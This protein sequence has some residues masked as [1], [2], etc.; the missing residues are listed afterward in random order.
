[1]KKSAF[2]LVMRRG[3]YLILIVFILTSCSKKQDSKACY[4]CTHN[5]SI[6][7]NIP[8]I[9]NAHAMS[10]TDVHCDFTNAQK[11]FYINTNNYADTIFLRND[12][13]I[14]EFWTTTCES[15]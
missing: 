8:K 1:M 9:V 4:S 3:L 10:L 11:M 7:S 13:T 15:E 5:D 14:V 12:T 2:N 6:W